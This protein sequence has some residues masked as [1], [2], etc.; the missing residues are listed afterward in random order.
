MSL[1]YTMVMTSR[2]AS[3]DDRVRASHRIPREYVARA[4]ERRERGAEHALEL[5]VEL[6][7]GPAVGAVQRADRPR[8]VEQV[9]LVVAHPEDLPGD[10]VGPVAAEIDHERRDL[11][12]RHLAETRHPALLLLGLGRDRID[13]AG[14]G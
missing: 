10:P 8:L 9:D 3:G 1:S 4:L 13:H 14:P 12:R 6:L 5:L 11:F 2:S 7:R